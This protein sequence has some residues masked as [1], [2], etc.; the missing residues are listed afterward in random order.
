[1]SSRRI[2]VISFMNH[3][4]AARRQRAALSHLDDRALEDLGL[5]RRD[6]DLESGRPFWDLPR[7]WIC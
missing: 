2:S 7:S 4:V 5:T 1:M 3:A 6:A